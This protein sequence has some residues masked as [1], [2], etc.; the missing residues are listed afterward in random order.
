MKAIT[1]FDF[2][3]INQNKTTGIFFIKNSNKEEFLSYRDLFNDVIKLL[4]SL[5]KKGIMEGDELVFQLKGNRE[6][7]TLFWA[8]ILGGIIP[9]PLAVVSNKESRNRFE[10]VWRTLSNPWLIYSEGNL[11]TI[12]K[13]NNCIGIEFEELQRDNF[14]GEI[15]EPSSDSIAFIQFSSGSTG[16]PKGV[17]LT[18]KNLTSNILAMIKCADLRETDSVFCWMPLTHDMGLIGLHLTALACSINQFI[19]PTDLFIRRPSLWMKKVN[20]HKVTILASPNFGYKHFLTHCKK[21]EIVKYDLSHVRR[22]L[23]G[24]EPISDTLCNTFLKE[25]EPCGLKPHSMFPVY[26]MAEA[27]LAITFPPVDERYVT[28]V[29]DRE[30]IKVGQKIQLVGDVS[31][32]NAICFVGVGTKVDNCDYQIWDESNK[33]VGD[34]VI[35]IIHIKGE[36][37]TKGYYNDIEGT[38]KAFRNGWLNTGDLGFVLKNNLF[39]TGRVKD[40]IFSNGQNYYAHDV[41]RVVEQIE[42]VELG[43][44]VACGVTINQEEEVILFLKKR[45]SQEKFVEIMDKTK[46]LVNEQ[47]GLDIKHIIPIQSIPKTTSGK[48]QRFK[49][50]LNYENGDYNAVI[51]DYEAQKIETLEYVEPEN[52]IEILLQRIWEQVL[53]IRKVGVTGN[54]FELGG[55]SVKGTVL[56]ASILKEMNVEV[57]LKS[58]FLNPTIRELTNHIKICSK[59]QFERIVPAEK[60]E[61]YPATTSQKRLF[62]LSKM[63]ARSTNYN[64]PGYFFLKGVLDV[65]RLKDT[66]QKLVNQYEILRTTFELRDDDPVQIIHEQLEIDIEVQ[67]CSIEEVEACVQEKIVPFNL[68]EL[69]LL[70]VLILRINAAEH[71]L[72]CDIHHIISD[73]F[74]SEIMI[75]NFTE[76]YAG[77]NPFDSTIIQY[78][79]YSIWQKK[80]F[81][82]ENFKVQRRYWCDKFADKVPVFELDTDFSRSKTQR[83]DGAVLTQK[84]D[85]TTVQNIKKYLANHSLTPYVF[86]LSVFKVLI[87]RYTTEEDIVIGTPVSGRKHPDTQEMLGLFVNTLVIRTLPEFQKS[88]VQFLSEVQTTVLEAYEHQDYPFEELLND[89]DLRR[90]MSRNPLF[91][92]SFSYQDN[93]NKEMT[94]NGVN[95]ELFE[96]E[97]KIS[98]FDLSLD[99]IEDKNGM[100]MR[101]EYAT[102]LFIE[103]RIQQF[104]NHFVNLISAILTDSN[105]KIGLLNYLSK[106]EKN[107]LLTQASGSEIEYP[108][109]SVIE[110]FENQVKVNPSHTALIFGDQ[111]ITYKE[112]NEQANKLAWR[113]KE[114]GLLSG[115]IVAILINPSFDMI[116]AILGVL[117]AGGAYLPIDSNYPDNRITYLLE[118][119]EAQ[120]VLTS[121]DL[122]SKINQFSEK[123]IVLDDWDSSQFSRINLNLKIEENQ[124]SYIIYTSG[125]SGRPKGVAIKQESFTDY[126][127]TFIQISELTAQDTVLQH[128]SFSFDTSIEE[129]FPVLCVGGSLLLPKNRK[130]LIEL[131]TYIEAGQLT[132]LSVSP[133]ILNY[134]NTEVEAIGNLRLIISGGDELKPHYY[135]QLIDRLKIYNS[136][137]PTESTVCITYYEVKGDELLVPIGKPIANRKVYIMDQS[138]QLVPFGQVGEL[139]VAGA[140]IALGYLNKEELTQQ[141]FILNP[142]DS[143]EVIYRTG[144]LVKWTAE[145]DLIF[146]GRVDRQVKVRGYRVELEEVEKR[147]LNLTGIQETVVTGLINKNNEKYLCAYYVGEEINDLT[148]KREL[149]IH[150]PDFMVPVHFIKLNNLPITSHGKLDLAALP[151]P[152]ENREG[153]SYLAPITE[154]EKNLVEIW[155]E[156]LNTETIGVLDDFFSL[157][158]D[159]IK[160]I[161]MVSRLKKYGLKIEIKDIFEYT[162]IRELAPF[163]KMDDTIAEQ[164]PIKGKNDLI[165]IQLA[166]FE[167][168]LKAPQFYTQGIRI[169]SRTRLENKRIN[170]SLTKLIQHHDVL[171]S[172]FVIEKTSMFQTYQEVE[173]T[174]LFSYKNYELSNE[175]AIETRINEVVSSVQERI[176]LSDGPLLHALHFTTTIGDHLIL[177]I[178]HLVIDGVS[179]RILL[180]DFLSLYTKE[181]EI[182]PAKTSAFKDWSNQLYRYAKTEILN[183][184]IQY[185]Q[186]VIKKT[187]LPLPKT[188]ITDELTYADV[189]SLSTS[190][191]VENTAYLQK[192]VN[193]AYNTEINDILI[194]TLAISLAKWT[195]HQ[196]IPI[197]LE[198]HGREAI[199]PDIDIS[200]T[201]GW[202]T[203]TFPVLLVIK[204]T[205]DIS[206]NIIE[207]KETLRKVPQKGIGYGVLKYLSE[208][209]QLNR[210]DPT[211]SFNYLGQFNNVNTA[212]FSISY[213]TDKETNSPSNQY[214]GDIEING[215]IINNQLVFHFSYNSKAFQKQT[216]QLL[217]DSFNENLIKIIAHCRLKKDTE[218]TQSDL[219]YNIDLDELDNIFS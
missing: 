95:F 208:E 53:N 205:E 165:P 216:I 32:K 41:E 79:D 187:D 215:M 38:K 135:N 219:S 174:P 182:L 5:Q 10:N 213:L 148:F 18:H 169:D 107:F 156:V 106:K 103:D 164:G 67:D 26:G 68:A 181:I 142:Y 150:L 202:F 178:H 48:V 99:I 29:I 90:D 110:L 89:L 185:W 189:L 60:R 145:G 8:C 50:A 212:S 200:R 87:A 96:P 21:T 151:E 160:A 44:A 175:D 17:S 37:V 194:T 144:D 161:Q 184:E 84:L 13:K 4:G 114:S 43:N 22:I 76:L 120:F 71:V 111:N 109:H 166:F 65:G 171:R 140:G 199:F 6:F 197:T 1:L 134:I 217:V 12:P 35:G 117:K 36:N 62:I 105:Q 82:S 158:G 116:Y 139:C 129:I 125:S 204:D 113:L 52:E 78:K 77:N 74:S 168:Q 59:S 157:G 127:N 155:Q 126:I 206:G 102:H 133:L 70:R 34:G 173:N 33:R 45:S 203:T 30:Q 211:I 108:K 100:G 97:L 61:Y 154:N 24:A 80:Y 159:S 218:I 81:E 128:S 58:L 11:V 196:Q 86:F 115:Q 28:A 143:E 138:Q 75:R 153:E 176:S 16:L 51:A 83:F 186:S 98:K 163:L 40:I 179:W 167:A 92:V 183:A 47:M 207:V 14:L 54:F 9:V 162:T 104:S 91:D 3:Q 7:I 73:G 122:K 119:S 130:D 15:K 19:M 46:A 94:M 72:I 124:R 195:K 180:E 2:Y 136:Y 147:I 23:N 214:K 69:P 210:V 85:A 188:T 66:F 57:S 55:H 112:L 39:V 131:S 172:V 20:E 121:A 93:G 132:V 42:E 141:K 198:G 31:L 192:N 49:L 170:D 27:S 64:M 118:D 152:I 209:A 63:H 101:F 25:L 123:V 56:I 190:F 191:S 146:L 177:L 193:H 88:F 201:I 137:G 149:K